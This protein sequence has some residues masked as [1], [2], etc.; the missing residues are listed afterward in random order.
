[1]GKFST[2]AVLTLGAV[3]LLAANIFIAVHIYSIYTAL[4]NDAVLINEL[5]LIRGTVQRIANLELQGNHSEAIKA[6]STVENVF[7]YYLA[8]A[9]QKSFAQS[10][11][12]LVQLLHNMRM[13]WNDFIA[14]IDAYQQEPDC[15]RRH[16]AANSA[17][18]WESTNHLMLRKVLNSNKTTNNIRLL[19][20]HVGFLFFSTVLIVL[21]VKIGIRSMEYRSTHD[22]LTGVGNRGAFDAR[23]EEEKLRLDRSGRAFSLCILD[24]DHFKIINDTYGHAAGDTVLKKLAEHMRITIRKID[25]LYRVGGEEFVV[26]AP[27]TDASQAVVLAEKLRVSVEQ[28]FAQTSIP[29]TVSIGV[30]QCDTN[31]T[32]CNLYKNADTALYEAKRTGRNKV[33]CFQEQHSTLERT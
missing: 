16:V 32:T 20:Y 23:L 28:V 9:G 18:L 17:K 12:D 24:I 22:A 21:I 11:P 5:G 33:V 7:H 15:F 19:F 30:S 3:V 14:N 10:N 25:G 2:S 13:E 4:H 29:L 26:L 31:T 27:D 1:M 8:G 6:R